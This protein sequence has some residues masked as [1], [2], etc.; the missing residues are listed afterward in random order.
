M[1]D[2]EEKRPAP[3]QVP[4]LVH[5]LVLAV[6]GG[7]LA[8]FAPFLIPLLAKSFAVFAV[9][10]TLIFPVF[11]E[12]WSLWPLTCLVAAGAALGLHLWA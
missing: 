2:A 5:V 3:R 9:V 11:R 10:A 7:G 1:S 4:W 12:R 8:F 6:T